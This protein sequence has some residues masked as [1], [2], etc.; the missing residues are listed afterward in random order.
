MWQRATDHVQAHADRTVPVAEIYD[1]WRQAPYGVKEGLLPALA[2]AFV[3]SQRNHVAVYREGIFRARFDDVDVQYLA[4]D[5]TFIQLRW[6]D[7]SD[8]ARRLLS[9][10]AEVVRGLDRTNTLTHLEPID[11][12]RGLVAVYEQLPGWT[13]RTMRLSANAVRVRELFRRARD[14]NQFLFN[15]I[16]L[17]LG[18]GPALDDSTLE[19][20]VL[21]V[22]QGLEE[23]VEAYP[24]MIHRLT[25][26]M[27]AELQVPNPSPQSLAELRDRAENIKQL[28]GDFHLDAFVGRLSHF[29]GTDLAFEGIASLAVNKPP[30]DWVDPDLDRGAIEIADLAQKFLRAETFARVKGRPEKRQAIAIVIGL[31]GRPTPMFKEFSVTDTDRAAVND[32]IERVSAL[33]DEDNSGRQSVI[34]A[35]LAQLSARY[36][37]NPVPLVATELE[38]T[39]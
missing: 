27:L 29:D 24:S 13:K 31:Q 3:M 6:M 16:P 25:D 5:P 2:V 20:V 7:L 38:G 28:A 23:L 4:K 15:D 32:L 9:G 1:L 12:A 14:P 17:T 11:V 35:A 30:R 33:F 34:L 10:M 22:R 36:M 8:V 21:G 19:R 26:I 18:D 37:N 39:S